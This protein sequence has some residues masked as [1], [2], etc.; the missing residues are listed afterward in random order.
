MRRMLNM[1]LL[2][3]AILVL[4]ACK[5]SDASVVNEKTTT[6]LSEQPAQIEQSAQITTN[7]KR[8]TNTSAASIPPLLP[9]SAFKTIE[10]TDLMPKED[11]DALLNPPSYVTDV[12]DGSFEDQ[13]SSQLQN[14]IA[15]AS[16]DRYQQA[17]ASTRIIPEMDGQAIRIPGFI[18]PL[19][20]DD[21]QTITQFFLVPF[22]GA[23]IHVP[24]PPPNQ[25]IFVN[26][27]QG[28]KLDALYD[29]FWISGI[30]NTSVV[31]ND[32]ATAAYSMQM[33]SYEAY[34]QD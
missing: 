20:F 21:E 10:W 5:Q 33:Q 28:L 19:E 24:P 14:S 32:M 25:I 15:A 1:T 27:P 7:S 22:F 11:L 26:F 12:E 3:I 30:V 17:L 4:M 29:P 34:T 31:E 2:G 16:D 23:C 18:V 13:I 6:T 9:E 8:S